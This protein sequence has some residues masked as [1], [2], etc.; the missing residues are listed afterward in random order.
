MNKVQWIFNAIV[1]VAVFVLV[2]KCFM[3]SEKTAYVDSVKLIS[4][5]DATVEMQKM[6]EQKRKVMEANIDT[7]G[8]ELQGEIKKFEA[9]RPKLSAKEISLNEA[10]LK[11]KQQQF[12]QYQRAVEQ[13]MQEEQKKIQ[14]E[15]LQR[16]NTYIK[17]Y[18][19]SHSYKYIMGATVTG[20]LIYAD[21]AY[22]I[23]DEI[24]EALN[25][26]HNRNQ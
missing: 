13:K 11:N 26:Q 6:L 2:V 3:T 22:D 15:V 5:Y 9:E 25:K 23:T 4:K 7:L 10:L 12:M 18:G 21:E 17:E 8:L 16:M 24:L 1:A 14:E 19:R 20:N